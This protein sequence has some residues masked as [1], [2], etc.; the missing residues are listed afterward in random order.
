MSNQTIYNAYRAAGLTHAGALAMLGNADCESNCIPYRMQGD[1]SKDFSKSKTYTADVDSGALDPW[2]FYY[3][4]IG[5]GLFQW[6]V[7]SRKKGLYEKAKSLGVSIGDESMQVA[8]SLSELASGYG[9]LLAYLRSTNDLYNAVSR[10]CKEYE[11]P[12]INNVDARYAAAQR[13]E[14]EIGGDPTP[15]AEYWPPRTIDKSMKGPDVAVLQAILK[16]RGYAINYISGEFDAL[17]DTETRKFQKDHGLTAD[18]VV[19]PLTWAK[20][21]EVKA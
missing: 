14:K 10:V 11:R 9:N 3:D 2:G 16:A 19:G 13:I 1:F 5:Y 20:L 6:T 4:A 8:Y 17:L 12:A 7:W 21:L 15:K 18:G